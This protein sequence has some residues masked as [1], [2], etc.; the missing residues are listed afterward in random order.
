MLVDAVPAQ[1]R[2]RVQ[3]AADLMMSLCG[4]TGGFA[5]GFIRAAV[6]FRVLALLALVLAGWMGALAWRTPATRPAAVRA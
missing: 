5:S 2:V 1:E 6:G 4:A 3:G